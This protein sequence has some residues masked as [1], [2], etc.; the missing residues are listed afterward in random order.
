[1]SSSLP[2]G[3]SFPWTNSRLIPYSGLLA[4]APQALQNAIG[5]PP[6]QQQYPVDSSRW[7]WLAAQNYA[8]VSSPIYGTLT[9]GR[10][11]SLLLDGVI[12]YDPMGG[13]YAFSPIGFSGT[14]CGAGDT[15]ECRFTTAVKYRQYRRLPGGGHRTVRHLFA[16]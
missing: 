6:N 14:T 11:N 4:N 12:A 5:V 13:S 2:A 7:G 1:M 10:Q 3:I 8:D 15:E 9:F 16:V